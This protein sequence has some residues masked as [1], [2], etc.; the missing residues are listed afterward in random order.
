MTGE[1]L[2]KTAIAILDDPRRRP[3][4]AE[5]PPKR[6]PLSFCFQVM[7]VDRASSRLNS[8]CS[9]VNGEGVDGLVGIGSRKVA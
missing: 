6:I 7:I 2:D 4:A 1:L 9:A 5:P 3:S 8:F